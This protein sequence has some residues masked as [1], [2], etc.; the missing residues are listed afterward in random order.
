MVDFVGRVIDIKRKG[1]GLERGEG[2]GALAFWQAR[3]TLID[4]EIEV[5]MFP[6][7]VNYTEIINIGG[8]EQREG[9]TKKDGKTPRLKNEIEQISF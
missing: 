1:K 8:G 4:M 5:S 3:F 7:L 6:S 9:E 2:E